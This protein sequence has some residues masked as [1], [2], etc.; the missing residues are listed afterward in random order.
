[1]KV[2]VLTMMD[3]LYRTV[4]YHLFHVSK[5]LDLQIEMSCMAT[6]GKEVVRWQRWQK[7]RWREQWLG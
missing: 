1:M 4:A 3:P 5:G 2:K 6:V 7:K